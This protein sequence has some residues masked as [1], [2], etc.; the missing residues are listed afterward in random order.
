V[1]HENQLVSDLLANARPLIRRFLSLQPEDARQR[2]DGIEAMVDGLLAELEPALFDEVF[3]WLESRAEAAAGTCRLCSR[4]CTRERKTVRVRTKRVQLRVP[5]TRYR[6]RSCGTNRA[7]MRE[8]LG[9]TSGMTTGGLD[10]AVTALAT[11]M[12]FGRAARQ[13]EEQRG[14]A[15]DR[16]LVERR[17]YAVGKDAEE[18]LAERRQR[19]RDEVMDA[20]GPRAGVDRVQLQVDGGGVPVG[21]LTRPSPSE[22]TER[23]PVRGLPKGKRPKTKR[24]VRVCMAWQDGVVEARA[25][26][27]HI[28]PHNQ[29]EVSG[30]RLYHVALEAG[31]GDDTHVHCTCDMAPWH[32]A[33]FEEQFSAHPNR[34]M[35]ADF[36]HTLEYIA[37]AGRSVEHA[38]R[39]DPRRWLAVQ[40]RRLKQGERDAIIDECKGH[41]CADGRCPLNDHG[42]CAV[43]A[44]RRYLRRFGEYMDYPRFIEEGLTIG[45]GAVEGRIRHLVRRRLDVPGDWREEN[46][47]PMLALISLRES[48]L[49]EEFWHWRDQRDRRRFGDRLRGV[50]LNRFRGKLPQQQATGTANER[51]DF[52]DLSPC[53]SA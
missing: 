42:E 22:A 10:R 28:A 18:Y 26:D 48:G 30:A 19:R 7:P 40:A 27:L 9:V 15:V 5:V 37:A 24:E 36:Y 13:L 4:R 46:L 49:W 3:S 17:T 53:F 32:R 35:C 29:T 23:T 20:V 12:S 44:A 50:G 41:S 6:C 52:D 2:L 25:V 39:S 16:T 21:K 51:I 38:D 1:A 31:A 8:W 11:E 14:H 34:S 47:H 43:R 45:S 33:Q